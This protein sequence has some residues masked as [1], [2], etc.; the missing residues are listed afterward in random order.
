MYYDKYSLI[1]SI[2]LYLTIIM[3]YG[4]IIICLRVWCYWYLTAA[5]YKGG[6]W[7]ADLTR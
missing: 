3:N 6:L 1:I 7:N 4:F 2:L 5:V